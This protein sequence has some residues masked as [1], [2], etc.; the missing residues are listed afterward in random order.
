M[1]LSNLKIAFL[2]GFTYFLFLIFTLTHYNIYSDAVN[3]LTRGQAY[4]HYFLTGKKD[5]SDLLSWKRYW[6]KPESLLIDADMPK[7][8]VVKRSIYQEDGVTFSYLMDYDGNGHP[9]L[10]DILSSFSNFIFFQKLGLIN[11]I[12][13]YRIYGVFLTA[14]LVGLIY[15]WGVKVYGNLAGIFAAFILAT[16]PL[17]WAHAHFNTEKDIPET[18]Y[19]AFFIF[20]VWRGIVKKSKLWLIGSGIFFGLAL[21]TKFNILFS[22]LVIIPWIFFMVT[23]IKKNVWIWTSL[24]TALFIGILIFVLSWPFLWPDPLGRIMVTLKFYKVLGLASE[25]PRLLPFF[26]I[27]TYALQTILFT[28]PIVILIFFSFGMVEV[29]GRLRYEK[30]KISLLFILWFFITLARVSLPGTNIYGGVRQIMEFIPPMAVISGLGASVLIQKLKFNFLKLLFVF[31]IFTSLVYSLVRLHPNEE[32]YFNSLI[33]GLAG[34][35]TRNFPHWGETY[36]A[37]YRAAAKWIND[38]GIEGSK[39]VFAY[40]LMPNIP[41]LFLRRNFDFSNTLRSGYLKDGEYAITLINQGFEGRSYYDLYLE[42]FIKPV[43]EAKVDNIPILKVWKN[44]EDHLKYPLVEKQDP[45]V[46]FQKTR[47]GIK[48]DLGEARR[49]SRLEIDY[50]NKESCKALLQGFLRI[51]KDG[52]NWEQIPGTLPDDWRISKLGEQPKEGHF[53]EPFVGQEARY[54]DLILLPTDTCLANVIRVRFFYFE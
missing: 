41:T 13:S 17:F 43:Y 35:K 20:S 37:S 30:D 44:S 6:Q 8:E 7:Q 5:Y 38:N 3:H 48:I 29:I 45:D 53:I 1:K 33:G 40:E 52:Q 24:A 42:N 49:I 50:N 51:S 10:S 31:F 54:I 11:D 4:L 19:F 9:P 27:N 28:T 18:V 12:D 34:A 47:E 36:G 46:S 15:W 22:V 14:L 23:Y 21:G 2:I 32:V 16:Y 25:T 26:G 39:V